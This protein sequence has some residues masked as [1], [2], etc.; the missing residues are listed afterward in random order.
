MQR[1]ADIIVLKCQLCWE[2][3]P[4]IIRKPPLGE[5]RREQDPGQYWQVDLSWFKAI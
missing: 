4:K 3:K 5:L 2:N 1:L